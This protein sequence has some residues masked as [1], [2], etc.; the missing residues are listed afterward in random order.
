M[1]TQM[2]F[3]ILH[4]E[5]AITKLSSELPELQSISNQTIH[6]NFFVKGS[7]KPPFPLDKTTTLAFVRVW[8]SDWY[9]EIEVNFETDRSV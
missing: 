6:H 3:H 9:D 8:D 7:I 2:P 1:A 5:A 4:H